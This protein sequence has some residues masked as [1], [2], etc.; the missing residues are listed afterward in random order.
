MEM[1]AVIRGIVPFGVND[2]PYFTIYFAHESDPDAI[3]EARLPANDVYPHP[4]VNDRVRVHYVL[5]VPT[6]IEK[7]P[8]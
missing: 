6:R 2:E 1:N 5:K 4:H 3:L 8:T 7:I